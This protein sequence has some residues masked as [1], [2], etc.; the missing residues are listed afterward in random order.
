MS[1]KEKQ[2]VFFPLLCGIMELRKI[3][4][5]WQQYCFDE[6]TAGTKHASRA[7]DF[8]LYLL[9]S[10]QYLKM[11]VYTSAAWKNTKLVQQKSE[12]N[13]L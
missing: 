8:T 5:L 1:E 3:L 6:N 13:L 4:E 2:W 7:V 9:D 12:N 10:Q 11:C